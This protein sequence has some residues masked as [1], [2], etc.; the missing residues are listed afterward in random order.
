MTT[1]IL[2]QVFQTFLHA[3]FSAPLI[4][5]RLAPTQ[6]STYS[7]EEMI[8]HQFQFQSA[9]E[10]FQHLRAFRAANHLEEMA[11]YAYSWCRDPLVSSFSGAMLLFHG[12]FISN[13]LFYSVY[14]IHIM[15]L[16]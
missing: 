12:V 1:Q 8:R 15:Y 3:L 2:S 13:T 5:S 6:H 11:G 9:W 7:S 10:A 16:L 14:V 4:L